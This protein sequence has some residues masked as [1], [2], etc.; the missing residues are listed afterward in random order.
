MKC[1][2]LIFGV[3]TIAILAWPPVYSIYLERD[4]KTWL[5]GRGRMEDFELQQFFG[6]QSS[7]AGFPSPQKA[8]YEVRVVLIAPSDFN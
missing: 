7:V 6:A 2:I 3:L 8:D 4:V 1:R 5:T